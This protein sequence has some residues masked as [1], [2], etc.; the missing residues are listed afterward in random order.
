MNSDWSIE[1]FSI[2]KSQS[3][4]QNA[5]TTFSKVVYECIDRE[6]LHTHILRSN[7]D[8]SPDPLFPVEPLTMVQH[9]IREADERWPLIGPLTF[10]SEWN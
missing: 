6:T 9:R 8:I 2:R 1:I 7:T 5:Y 10:L 4:N 3:T